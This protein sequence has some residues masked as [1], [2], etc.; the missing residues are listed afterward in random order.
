MRVVQCLDRGDY[1]Y[2]VGGHTPRVA[3]RKWIVRVGALHDVRMPQRGGGIGLALEPLPVFRVGAHGG[4]EHLERIAARQARM[5]GPVTPRPCRLRPRIARLC[6]RQ[7]P[8]L[9]RAA[10]VQ[11]TGRSEMLYRPMTD[12]DADEV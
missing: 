3:L 11:F 2:H 12:A 9:P 7:S 5:L 10:G 4:P 6:T 1:A 8:G